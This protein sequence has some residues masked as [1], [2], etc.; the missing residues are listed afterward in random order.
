ME[1]RVLYTDLFGT[2]AADV[3]DHLCPPAQHDL[4]SISRHFN[5]NEDKYKIVG[6]SL[7]GPT[8]F[9]LSLICIDLE[10]STP[11]K[12]HIVKINYYPDDDEDIL[13]TLFKR[14]EIVL[15]DKY[16]SKYPKKEYDDVVSY[17][18]LFP[19]EEE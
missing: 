18:D 15:Y 6:L 17:S 8:N 19:S 4:K 2:V 1:A 5:L 12:E 11:E 7:F 13:D 14:L 10:K 9:S 16:D 3:D